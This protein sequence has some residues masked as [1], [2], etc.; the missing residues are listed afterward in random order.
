M[1]YEMTV[2]MND[3]VAQVFI[4]KPSFTTLAPT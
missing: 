1:D 4:E 2:L 3:R